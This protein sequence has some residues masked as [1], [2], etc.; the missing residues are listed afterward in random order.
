MELLFI[1]CLI[2]SR[3]N[4]LWRYFGQV[5]CAVSGNPPTLLVA[6][7]QANLHASPQ[8]ISGLIGRCSTE[9][10]RGICGE[11]IFY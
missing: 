1:L 3:I 2:W 10:T 8:Q 11:K 5:Y 6:L 9:T 4:A 7:C